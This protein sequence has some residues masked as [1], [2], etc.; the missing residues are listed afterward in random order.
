[1]QYTEIPELIVGATTMLPVKYYNASG[2]ETI[3]CP[4]VYTDDCKFF[5]ENDIVVSMEELN[6]E[7]IVYGCPASDKSEESEV[8]VFADNRS[9][10]DTLKELVRLCKENFL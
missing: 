10:A 3:L 7:Y 4:N 2:C 9:C 5:L 6:G 1:M 8:I